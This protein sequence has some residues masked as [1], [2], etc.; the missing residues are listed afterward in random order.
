VTFD[1]RVVVQDEDAVGA[2]P[3]IELDTVDASGHNRLQSIDCV[4]EVA[5]DDHRLAASRVERVEDVDPLLEVAPGEEMLSHSL[6]G[7]VAETGRLVLVL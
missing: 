3:D 5:E 2:S 1:L 6:A 7:V 4:P